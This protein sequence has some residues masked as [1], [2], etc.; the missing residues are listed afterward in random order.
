L[1]ISGT[2]HA[3]QRLAGLVALPHQTTDSGTA[4]ADATGDADANS[5]A[6]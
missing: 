3:D 4:G 2:D 1:V 6:C 5:T